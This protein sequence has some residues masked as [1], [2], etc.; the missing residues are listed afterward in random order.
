ML[1]SVSDAFEREFRAVLGHFASGIAVV[2]AMSDGQPVGMTI[3]SLCSLSLNPPLLVIC[4][5]TT[6]P[7]WPH[8]RAASTLCVNI[9]AE[10][11]ADLA[12]QFARSGSDKYN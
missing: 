8:I 2:T 1:A 7:T 10:G 12:R 9:L 5:N 11:Q 6:P 4:P 3:Q